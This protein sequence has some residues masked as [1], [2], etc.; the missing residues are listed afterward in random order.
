MARCE[1][2]IA[3]HN[4]YELP[5]FCFHKHSS[6]IKMPEIR[7]TSMETLE[8][9]TELVRQGRFGDAIRALDGADG[10]RSHRAGSA[11]LRAELL[12]RI[13]HHGQSRALAE[14][15][16]KSKSLSGQERAG[17]ELTLARVLL[18]AGST[19]AAIVHF[20]R[21]ISLARQAGDFERLCWSQIRLLNTLAERSAPAA[22]ASL[23]SDV[24]TNA[25]RTGNPQVFA[26]LHIYFGEMEAKRGLLKS[27]RRHTRLG[28]DILLNAPNAWLEA[29]AENTNLAIAVL[30]SD[31]E[32]GLVHGRRALTSAEQSGSA[33]TLRACLGN[34]G[35]LYFIVGDFDQAVEY[36]ERALAALPSHGEHTNAN[37]DSLARIRLT[38][39]LVDDCA[40]LLGRIAD[41]IQTPADML[42]YAN[43][44]SQLTKTHLAGRQKQWADALDNVTAVTDLAILTKDKIL[45]ELTIL[46]KAEILQQAG[47]VASFKRLQDNSR[48]CARNTN[49]F[50][51][52]D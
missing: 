9:V 8:I 11:V 27:A 2:E 31:F 33:S 39:G 20:Q 26:A 23:L 49:E 21:A 10:G 14:Q 43:R 36:F 22:T 5:V 7:G 47:R 34:L 25:I 40:L 15:L 3:A 32:L 17:C 52:A 50:L 16:L 18:D 46:T 48:K 35:N 51:R 29:V 45:S 4:S 42:L 41:S 37:F 6:S 38:Q 24:R 1:P 44:Y 30:C 19:E 12:E 28:Q 13:G